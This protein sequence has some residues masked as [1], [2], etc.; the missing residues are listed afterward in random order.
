MEPALGIIAASVTSM[1][2][3]FQGW[4]FG[5]ST[6][7]KQ[8]GPSGQAQI[9]SGSHPGHKEALT[10]R[11]KG[12]F[13]DESN[14]TGRT[15]DDMERALSPEGSDIELNKTVREDRGSSSHEHDYP[16]SRPSS[17]LGQRSRSPAREGQTSQQRPVIN[18]RTTIDIR[19]H[20]ID[21][22]LPPPTTCVS[23]NSSDDDERARK[24][25]M[26]ADRL[27]PHPGSEK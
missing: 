16:E 8:S 1:R 17:G 23:D 5:W 10:P 9:D 20:S 26:P 15:Y 14:Y 4:G 19:S 12:T 7:S 21:H 25:D 22:I 11:T 6:N 13:S 18:V 3:L 24:R 27:G 2:P